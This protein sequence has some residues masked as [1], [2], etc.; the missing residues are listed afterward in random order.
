MPQV[1]VYS[2]NM[3]GTCEMVK[4]YLTLRGVEFTE[5]N[6]SADPEGRSQMLLLGYDATPVT[7]I[8]EKVVEGFDTAQIDAALNDLPA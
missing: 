1:T 3:C 2:S 6:V 7:V 5:R 4:G 8:G